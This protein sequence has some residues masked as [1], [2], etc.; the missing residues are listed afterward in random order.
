MIV[1]NE[2]SERL[3]RLAGRTLMLLAQGMPGHR[4]VTARFV[5]IDFDVVA[6][7]VGRVEAEDGVGGDPLFGD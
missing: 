6:D 3:M 1:R 7:R 5:G 4:N 2:I